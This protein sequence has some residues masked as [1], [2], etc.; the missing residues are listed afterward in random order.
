MLFFD[1]IQTTCQER[2]EQKNRLI[3]SSGG[4]ARLTPI[5]YYVIV[6]LSFLCTKHKNY[7]F[8]AEKLQSKSL[9]IFDI[10]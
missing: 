5:I 9:H 10:L 6:P 2:I 4:Y 1:K 8:C 7:N 3:N